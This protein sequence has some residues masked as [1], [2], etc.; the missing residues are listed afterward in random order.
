MRRAHGN[1]IFEIKMMSLSKEWIEVSIASSGKGFVRELSNLLKKNNA[2]DIL[3]C[4]CGGGHII[5]Q[6]SK[7]G[8]NCIGIDLTKEMIDYAKQNYSNKNLEYLRLNWINLNKLN[9]KF[10]SIICR[11]NSLVCGTSWEKSKEKFN[12]KEAEIFIS[13]S[14][15]AMFNQLK[16]NGLLYLDTIS[17]REIDNDGGAIKIKTVNLDL[18]GKIEYDWEKRLRYI[19]GEGY[20][21]KEYYKGNSTSYLITPKELEKIVKFFKTK[22]VWFPNFKNETNYDII[23]AIK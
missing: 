16:E 15:K 23:C 7:N 20:V 1:R 14:I 22:K 13:K 21:N 3:E 19:S 2:T 6:L 8:F 9:K 18:K 17:Q 5:Y 4:G 11:G 12:S 10:D